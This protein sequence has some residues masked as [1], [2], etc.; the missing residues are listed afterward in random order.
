MTIRD[1]RQSRVASGS[2]YVHWLTDEYMNPPVRSPLRPSTFIGDVSPMNVIGY[3][4]QY[5]K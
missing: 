2:L 1:T 5:N 3:I 4:H